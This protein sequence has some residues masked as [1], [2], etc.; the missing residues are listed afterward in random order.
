MIDAR[1]ARR[2]RF[3]DKLAT[4]AVRGAG[5]MVLASILLILA[6]LV[7]TCLPLAASASLGELSSND[8]D[9]ARVHA[10]RES[11]GSLWQLPPPPDSDPEWS[12]GAVVRTSGSRALAVQGAGLHLYDLVS[13]VGI[14]DTTQRLVPGARWR[15]SAPIAMEPMALAFDSVGSA[16]LAAWY[17]ADG[18]L[19]A[20]SF[21]LSSATRST[22]RL[23][24]IGA[25]RLRAG[26]LLA[27]ARSQ[28]IIVLEN[29]RFLRWRPG[30]TDTDTPVVRGGQFTGL[31]AEV[32]AAAW[33]PG[34]ETL[35]LATRDGFLH[36]FDLAR[37]TLPRLGAP[38][39]IGAPVRWIG[40]ERDRRLSALLTERQELL[41]VVPTTGKVV[42]RRELKG[43]PPA[44]SPGLSADGAYLYFLS[45]D[46]E[47]RWP[48]R[49]GSPDTGWRSLWQAQRYGAYD[50]AAH[51]W[52]PEGAAIGV[53]PK[54][55]LT[56]LFW[57]TFKAA[58]YGMLIAV[59]VA[60]GAAIYTG[61][62]LPPR[63]RNQVKPAIEM[64]EAF[65][66]VVLGFIAGLWLAPLLAE[67]LFFVLAAPLVLLL[68][69][70]LLAALHLLL[71]RSSALFVRRAPRVALVMLTYGLGLWLLWSCSGTLEEWLFDGSLR[72]WL[73]R[74]HGLRYD[75]RNA[76]LVGLVM[77]LAITPVMF[78]I[79][80]DAINA[81]PRSLSDGSLAL[82]ATRWQSLARVVLPAASPAILSALLIGLAR[83]LG[84]TMIVLL[85][86]GN[87]PLMTSDPFSGLR[88]LAAS[89]VVEL[90][91]ADSGGVHFRLLFLAALVLFA[92]TFLLNTVAELF[93]QRLRYAYAGR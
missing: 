13:L 24:T 77:G 14:A 5:G 31:G 51:V 89:I 36:R 60:L 30:E 71:Q 25:P 68:V 42:L 18:T 44:A 74:S 58:I 21:D 53:L 65:P 93:R 82:G 17:T 84:E 62:F 34:R 49:S 69:P 35:L 64:L 86:T 22:S 56:P 38:L 33:G 23:R 26:H 12:T 92:M 15:A 57:G 46:S 73:W 85:A 3:R 10:M 37:P 41:L 28:E 9:R 83:G 20:R 8:L 48:L 16:A 80:E 52:H 54:Y 78:S 67:H 91:E 70:L 45:E 11:D 81:V 6:Y 61:Y 29:D 2:R 66:T 32:L 90:P 40:S 87:S 88:S 76:L 39:P 47:I 79:V 63:R 55:G 4:V 19:H 1:I 50:D 7:Y 27:D 43:L 75:Q 59:P 72:D